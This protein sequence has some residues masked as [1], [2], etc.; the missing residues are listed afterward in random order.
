MFSVVLIQSENS[1]NI[2]ALARAMANFDLDNLILI[3][4]KVDHLNDEALNRSKH[5]KEIL[6][7]A[8]IKPVNY[9]SKNSKSNLF[10]DFDYCIAFTSVLGTDYNLIRTPLSPQ[11]FTEA[12]DEKKSYALIFGRD[13]SGLTNEEI[14]MCDYPVTIETSKNYPAMNLSHAASLIFYE[15]SKKFGQNKI[16]KHIK[17]SD[18]KTK[19][20]IIN[21]LNEIIDSIE[22]STLQKKE[23]QYVVWKRV[24]SKSHLTNR[25]AFA[26]LGLLKKILEKL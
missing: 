21:K 4:P 6:K 15:I 19:E 23:T 9:F 20:V 17:D 22:F 13:G 24:I 1:G 5:A 8:K 11:K 18:D 10:K 14:K 25:E 26:V 7:S 16:S 2:G 12:I 3:D